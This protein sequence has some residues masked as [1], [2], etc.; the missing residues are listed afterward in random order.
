[1]PSVATVNGAEPLT[2]SVAEAWPV[3]LPAVGEVNTIVHW[4]AR[5]VFAPA[6]SQVLATAS[7]T[8]PAPL[9]FVSVKSTCSLAAATNVPVPL[10]FC[11][12][13]VKVCGLPTSFVALGVI[14][15]RASTQVLTAATELP[16]WPF[17]VRS[18]F[19]LLTETVVL[20]VTVVEPVVG[21]VRPM[22]H[23]PVAPTVAQGFVV[24]KRARARCD[25]EGHAV[26]AGAGAK[27]PPSFTFTC[28]VNVCV[29][30]TRLTPFGVIWMFASTTR[31]GSHAPSDG[32]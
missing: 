22:V 4:P 28:A 32:V 27:P 20:A 5:S 16:F 13:T 10:S 15:I 31:S 18:R 14:E 19:T 11:S 23:S 12:V 9:E 25:G 6:L 21:E 2:A 8:A 24:V 7:S 26:P 1:M 17:V 30:P 3:T 29:W